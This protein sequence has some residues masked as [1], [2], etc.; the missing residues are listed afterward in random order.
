[1]TTRPLK[2]GITLPGNTSIPDLVEEAKRAE[3]A[4]FDVILT[5]DHL[6]LAS[7]HVL[8]DVREAHHRAAVN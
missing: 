8:G 5:P 3:A 2:L 6:G 1:M 7:P 4:G